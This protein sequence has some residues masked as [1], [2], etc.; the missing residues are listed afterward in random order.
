MYYNGQEEYYNVLMNIPAWKKHYHRILM[1][2]YY[3]IRNVMHY[4]SG[5]PP[6][7]VGHIGLTI[8]FKKLSTELY[9]TYIQH[10]CKQNS[11]VKLIILI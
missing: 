1:W 4:G 3:V 10:M 11:K 5:F 6:E 8:I 9:D 7:I 2:G